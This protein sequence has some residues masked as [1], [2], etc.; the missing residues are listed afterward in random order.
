MKEGEG[1]TNVAEGQRK[2][3]R[4]AGQARVACERCRACAYSPTVTVVRTLRVGT[5]PAPSGKSVLLLS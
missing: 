2:W 3:S 1:G 5:L 4:G